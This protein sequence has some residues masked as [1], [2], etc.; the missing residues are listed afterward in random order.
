MEYY[1]IT[2]MVF[3]P[4]L[5]AALQALLPT[6][7]Q[8]GRAG[9]AGTDVI[10]RWI[11]LAS[12][13]TSAAF[14]FVLLFSMNPTI[15]GL[16]M[17][18]TFPWIASYS[19]SYDMA[20]DGLNILLVALIAI[21]F[22]ILIAAE[23]RQKNSPR[24]MHGLLLLLQTALS[25]AACAQ[26]TFLQFVFWGLAA[27]PFYF[28]I[29]IWGSEQKEET[30]FRHIIA[31]SLGNAM[32]FGALLLVYYSAEPHTFSLRELAGKKLA[33]KTFELSG[34][35]IG[36]SWA[37]C[38]LMGLGFA[39]RAPV[40]PIHGW[41]TQLA[42]HAPPTVFVAQSVASLTA[43]YL[44]LRASLTLF[45]EVTTSIAGGLVAIGVV[46]LVVGAVCAVGQRDLRLLLAYVCIAQVG[47]ML[48]GMGSLRS[49]GVVGSVFGILS[50]GLAITGFGLFLTSIVSRTSEGAF[51]TS[52]G[53]RVLGGLAG[54]APFLATLM[55]IVLASLIGL[56]GV[57]GFVGHSLIVMGSFPAHPWV[58]LIAG[59]SLILLIYCLF[60][61]YRMVFLGTPGVRSAAGTDAD[62]V[63]SYR[64]QTYLLPVASFIVLCGIYP[65][66]LID[67]V[68]TTVGAFLGQMGQMK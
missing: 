4:L 19:I 40:W 26:D 62:M 31:A 57:G 66:P 2:P 44:F 39:F 7:L 36:V 18:E 29:G 9:S 32:V 47:L 61:M 24:G 35:E 46:N 68:V 53:Q 42:R 65:K 59:L 16:Q 67:L 20:V 15:A 41:F 12:S 13:L 64:E 30:A 11:A 28:L 38:F 21:V 34:I 60:A 58:V 49:A 3:I 6:G 23:W 5:G 50:A 55:G 56:P 54:R 51:I 52:D 27:L 37:V 22:P 17:N 63:L 48:V 33:G 14:A 25:G 10:G 1:L 45:P 43:V 8:L